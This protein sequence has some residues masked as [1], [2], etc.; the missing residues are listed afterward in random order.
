M[1]EGAPAGTDDGTVAG[2]ADGTV[3][4][5]VDGTVDGAPAG[6]STKRHEKPCAQRIGQSR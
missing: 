1:P 4:G 5:T 3:A 2:T 6:T